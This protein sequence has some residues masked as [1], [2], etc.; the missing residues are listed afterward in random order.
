MSKFNSGYKDEA[1]IPLNKKRPGGRRFLLIILSC[2]LVVLTLTGIFAIIKNRNKS[3]IKNN[4]LVSYPVRSPISTKEQRKKI[5]SLKLKA[6]Q[7]AY[8]SNSN[9]S[10]YILLD[11]ASSAAQLGLNEK[12]DEYIKAAE[13]NS[14]SIEGTEKDRINAF[15]E[16]VRN[17]KAL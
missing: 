8:A 2:I 14:A 4:D 17:Q 16:S 13:K 5:L 6:F 7:E 9:I 12:R 11:S 10:I 1:L 3:A 15:I